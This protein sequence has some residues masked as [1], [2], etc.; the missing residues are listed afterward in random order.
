M[1]YPLPVHEDE[2][3]LGDKPFARRQHKRRLP[4]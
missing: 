2:I 1:S 3:R 4:E